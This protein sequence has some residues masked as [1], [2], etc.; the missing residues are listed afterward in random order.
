MYV[1]DKSL[2]GCIAYAQSGKIELDK[3]TQKQLKELFDL[4]YKGITK[5]A[6]AAKEE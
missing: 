4:G 2:K 5:E 1:V 3:A 6:K